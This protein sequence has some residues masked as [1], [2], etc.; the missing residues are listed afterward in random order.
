[1]NLLKYLLGAVLLLTVTVS[2]K[3]DNFDDVSFV[4]AGAA[5]EAL[6]ALFEITQDNTGLV[7]ITPN[8]TGAVYYDIYF[9]DATAAPVKVVAG[10]NTSHTYAEGVYNV[11]LVGHAVNGK[12]F[13]ATQQ[14]TVSFRAPVNLVVNAAVDAVNNFKVNVSAS[15]TYET[16]FRVYWG[17]VPNE[18]PQTF[19][20]GAT[21]SHIY[22]AVGTYT[23]RVVALSGGAA[24]T[25]FTTNITITD[26]VLLP[27]TFQ[28]ATQGYSF[29]NF[30]G[31]V[32]TVI[33]NTQANGINT[34]TRVARMVKG[35]G[36]P[37]GG[38]IL[39]LGAPIDFTANRVFRMKVYSPRVGA[40]VLL[41]VENPTNGGISFE[42]EV[43]TSVANAWEDLVF[44]YNAINPAN[45]YQNLVIIFDNGTVGDG[46]PN[47]TFL[48]DDI[49]LTNQIPTSLL[50][51]PV[52]F[53]LAGINYAVTDFGSTI[54]F[55]A[56]DPVNAA[57]KVK[58]TTKPTGAPTWAG[59]TIGSGFTSRIPFTATNTQ[60]SIR[61]Y[62]PAAGIRVRLKA[63]DRTN[64]TRSVETEAMTLTANAW[65]TLVFDFANQS[66]GTAAMNLT[67][68]YDM[69]SVFF[70]F[71]TDGSGKVFYWDD[72]RFLAANVTPAYLALPLD[73]QSTVINYAFTNFGG[74]NATVVDNPSA[75]GINT[76]TRVGKMVKN[77]GEV[78]GGSLIALVNPI[79]FSVN[80]TMRMKVWSPRVGAKVL[81]KV[82]GPNGANFE[83][84]VLT[85]TA[86]N[87]EQLTF[88]Y[89]AINAGNSYQSVVLIFDLG[90]MGNG[91]ANF[92]WYFD[93]I[94]LN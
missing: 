9:G 52:T 72:V 37:W 11:K 85:T 71:G 1:M 81:L 89:T 31:G 79:N 26:P 12:T 33:N 29:I 17:D 43:L 74:G 76:S 28:S 19:L 24:T 75:T 67:Y 73:F 41:K 35:A 46:S 80:R 90:I 14:L 45:V 86:N 30:D 69:A 7:T 59:T 65:E 8:G 94:T 10:K 58:Q 47:F 77:A 64:N 44:N 91:S 62:S 15:A 49:R 40:K 83:K 50:D 48:F 38:T 93:D 36:Q 18:V 21:I 70:D 60:M 23:I 87:W 39:K 2:C 78:Y 66:A 16:M 25:T 3:K 88:D 22:A 68:N 32:A 20:E 84:E 5:P 82:E 57:N 55:D 6:S 4:A 63:E 27:V 56:N 53:D 42:K 13:E 54:T 51:L 34:S 61:V 92:T